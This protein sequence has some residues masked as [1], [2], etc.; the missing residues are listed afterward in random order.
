MTIEEIRSLKDDADWQA[1][2]TNGV[3]GANG[4]YG[5]GNGS[6]KGSL[7]YLGDYMD[8]LRYFEIKCCLKTYV[9]CSL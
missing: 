6:L 2:G 4:L 7:G 1:T 3:H 5:A 9:F 8:D